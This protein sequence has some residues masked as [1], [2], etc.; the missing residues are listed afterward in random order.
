[1]IYTDGASSGNPGS[2]GWGA[3]IIDPQQ[4]VYEL[5]DAYPYTTNNEME[6]VAALNALKSLKNW[7]CPIL[8]YTDSR[9][10]IQSITQWIH[11]WKKNDWKNSQKKPVIHLQ[12]W[13][14]FLQFPL[15]QIQWFHVPGHQ[16]YLG[17][18]RADAIAVAFSKGKCPSLFKGPLQKYPYL[19]NSHSL[20]THASYPCYLAWINGKLKRY[21][22][23]KECEY[24]IKYQS[25]IPFKKVKSPEEENLVLENWKTLFR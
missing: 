7:E 11:L 22:S 13:K 21:S 16:G 10:L 24:E 3:I 9:Y 14:E 17:N 6:I 4:Y 20:T 15:H 19:K 5:G 18:E 25:K 1:M 12:L 23:W 8:I 2:G